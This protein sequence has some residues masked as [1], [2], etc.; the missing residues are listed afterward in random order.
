MNINKGAENEDEMEERYASLMKKMTPNT[1]DGEKIAEEEGG[2]EEEPVRTTPI[3]QELVR[4]AVN[5]LVEAEEANEDDDETASK[6]SS[7]PSAFENRTGMGFT[8]GEK[9]SEA[10]EDEEAEEEEDKAEEEAEAEEEEDDERDQTLCGEDF[11][12]TAE[13]PESIL[14][15]AK[16]FRFPQTP[17]S[18]KNLVIIG[19]ENAS[20]GK[21]ITAEEG[22]SEQQ[23]SPLAA[24]SPIVLD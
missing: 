17:M 19:E 13:L 2:K 23:R 15:K 11:D 3:V 14:K 1:T 5:N 18:P 9:S 21:T 4:E 6:L 8:Q 24:N 16:H 22:G 10:E 7:L 20:R 12:K